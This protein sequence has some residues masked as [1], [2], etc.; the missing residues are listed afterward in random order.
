LSE[1]IFCKDKISATALKSDAEFGFGF[2][3]ST[4]TCLVFGYGSGLGEDRLSV[5]SWKYTVLN[6]SLTLEN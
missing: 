6:P 1:E 2:G 4:I 5:L 3:I